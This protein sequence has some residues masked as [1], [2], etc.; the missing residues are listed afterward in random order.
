MKIK[1]D[2]I[3]KVVNSTIKVGDYVICTQTLEIPAGW[4]VCKNKYT[5]DKIYRVTQVTDPTLYKGEPYF[6]IR[7]DLGQRSKIK[8]S[9][10]KHFRLYENQLQN[11]GR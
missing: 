11:K 8:F 9:K 4:S 7:N 10:N 5:K 3:G 2:I 6:Q 1:Y